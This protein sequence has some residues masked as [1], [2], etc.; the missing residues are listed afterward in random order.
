MPQ[1]AKSREQ[2]LLEERISKATALVKTMRMQ[3]QSVR[4]RNKA[5]RER[6]RRSSKCKS[7]KEKGEQEFLK[8]MEDVSAGAITVPVGADF[9]NKRQT[10]MDDDND[11]DAP[12]EKRAKNVPGIG[13]SDIT[14]GSSSSN[15]KQ[16][17]GVWR[18][19]KYQN[20][21]GGVGILI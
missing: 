16:W 15:S 21:S 9:K 18:N 17:W 1:I 7:L 14:G 3:L 11:L 19:S 12:F 5:E 8:L 4:K 6:Q 13:A 20:V 10:D 2:L